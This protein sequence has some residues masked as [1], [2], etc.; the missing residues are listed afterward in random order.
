[1]SES[2]LDQEI[3]SFVFH[4]AKY[5]NGKNEVLSPIEW[6]KQDEQKSWLGIY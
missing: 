4:T 2:I 1:M 6:L 3:I 5:G